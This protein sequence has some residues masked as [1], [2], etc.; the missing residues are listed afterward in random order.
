MA[1]AADQVM[2]KEVDAWKIAYCN[3]SP[4]ASL[5]LNADFMGQLR[6]ENDGEIAKSRIYRWSSFSGR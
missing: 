6:R 5:S 3:G 1:T 2:K 4:L